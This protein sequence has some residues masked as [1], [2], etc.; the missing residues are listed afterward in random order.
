MNRI[1]VMTQYEIERL[2]YI[3]ALI[4]DHIYW[5]SRINIKNNDKDRGKL[6]SRI[7]E[8][9]VRGRY[10]SRSIYC[11]ILLLSLFYAWLCRLYGVSVYGV[12]LSVY[13]HA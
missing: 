8:F 9:I 2:R 7:N 5:K 3:P 6:Y 13:I 1:G 11:S 10:L 12:L 4:Q